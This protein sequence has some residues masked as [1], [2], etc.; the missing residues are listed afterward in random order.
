MTTNQSHSLSAILYIRVST[1]EQ[2]IRG[3]SLKTQEDA[4]RQYCQLRNITIKRVYIEDHSA[5]H[6]TA[7]NGKINCRNKKL[8]ASNRIGAVYEMESIQSKCR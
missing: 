7:Q 2:A 5:K 6:S 4:L 3:G 8:H 1:E